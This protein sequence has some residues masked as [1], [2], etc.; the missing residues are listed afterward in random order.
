MTDLIGRIYQDLRQQN[1][2]TER[3]L[4]TLATKIEPAAIPTRAVLWHWDSTATVGSALGAA[5]DANQLFSHY[6]VQAPSALGDTFTHSA[7][8]AAGDYLVTVHGIQN[9]SSG[10]VTWSVDDV[11]VAAQDWYVAGIGY[12]TL[13]T[14]AVQLP[15]AGYHVL[16][17]QVLGKNGASSGYD[18][19]L[20]RILWKQASDV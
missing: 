20:T 1:A 17:G 15:S 3:R 7:V 18:L 4:T 16:K 13:A 10:I 8:L 9:T 2:A 6:G 14:F 19:L 5:I 12:N 11:V